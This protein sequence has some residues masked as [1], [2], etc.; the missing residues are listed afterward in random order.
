VKILPNKD[1]KREIRMREENGI[2]TYKW[3]PKTAGAPIL[4]ITK[5]SIGGYGFC[6]LNYK[7]GYIDSLKQKVSPAMIK[8]TIVHDAQEEFWKIMKIDDA[9]KLVSEPAKLQKHFRSLYPETDK[10]DIEDLYRS[11]SA[12]NTERFIESH[13]EE[14]LDE[15]IPPGNEITLHARYTTDS[16]IEVHMMGIID[17]LFLENGGYI[18]MELKTGLWKDSAKTR[19]RKEMAFYKMLFENADPDDVRAIGLDP[20]IPFTHWGWYFPASNYVYVEKVLKTSETA[21]KRSF[22]KLIESYLEEQFPASFF[23]KKCIHCGYYDI[24][25]A[26]E[27]GDENDW[28]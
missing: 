5:S 1:A 8:G 2:Y 17:R 19:M 10:E 24:C 14:T 21:V 12:Y 22:D 26:V 6:K 3:E 23:Y 15:F 20:D 11:M 4:K 28:F 7:Y 9:S 25:E 13:E 16:G 18:P 27:G